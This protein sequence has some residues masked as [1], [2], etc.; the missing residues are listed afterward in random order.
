[1]SGCL[2]VG[3]PKR[4]NDWFQFGRNIGGERIYDTGIQFSFGQD[5]YCQQLGVHSL[6]HYY[7]PGGRQTQVT[8]T[9]P[10]SVGLVL[11]SSYQR[12]W[13]LDNLDAAWKTPDGTYQYHSGIPYGYRNKTEI[14]YNHWNFEIQYTTVSNDRD[15]ATTDAYRIVHFAIEPLSIHHDINM[16]EPQLT[17][18]MMDEWNAMASGKGKLH[19]EEWK[20]LQQEY[21]DKEARLH[22]RRKAL[23]EIPIRNPIPSCTAGSTAHTT[24][25]MVKENEGFQAYTLHTYDVTWIK[26]DEN[27]K[28]KAW[29][30]R[31]DVYLSMNNVIPQ[32]IHNANLCAGVSIALVLLMCTI[33]TIMRHLQS[34]QSTVFEEEQGNDRQRTLAIANIAL[35]PP[36]FCPLMIPVLCGYGA[37][38]LVTTV[39]VIGSSFLGWIS[40]V[41]RGSRISLA[42]V[43]WS[44]CGIVAGYTAGWLSR[45]THRNMNP[46]SLFVGL[47]LWGPGFVGLFVL[48]FQLWA[49]DWSSPY[50]LRQK[51]YVVLIILLVAVYIPLVRVGVW[52]AGSDK[53]GRQQRQERHSRDIPEDVLVPRQPWHCDG[54]LH[55]LGASI[56]PF[57]VIY[58]EV[59][60]IMGALWRDQ[61]YFSHTGTF[62]VV[63]ASA[64][65]IVAAQSVLLCH[66]QLLHRN[67]S[68]W[69]RAFW[70]GGSFGLHVLLYSFR[71]FQELHPVLYFYD[72]D[73]YDDYT[74]AL[75]SFYGYM[76]AFS[77]LLVC[78]GGFVGVVC[79]L[80][81][82]RHFRSKLYTIPA[83]VMHG[84]G[85]GHET[86]GILV[87][88]TDCIEFSKRDVA[89]R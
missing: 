87:V 6:R 73:D 70:N 68:W 37:Q 36:T 35:R 53:E 15:G 24:Q 30:S 69:W 2:G 54:M 17:S 47:I 86:E 34:K 50:E 72:Y 29:S 63:L 11:D 71:Y 66:W 46:R 20:R 32:G 64:L 31:W 1:M 18:G 89:L 28:E 77:L 41:R 38:A 4:S 27:E 78:M 52:A 65:A 51:S 12:H 33:V 67:H 62:F 22:Q 19:K 43:Y 7:H 3:T 23:E 13:I 84:N 76:T 16:T 74:G 44:I 5:K 57:S 85:K 40:P 82:L 59:Y 60:F 21:S 83:S 39:L 25:A 10:C 80:L 42:I 58:V 14:V 45:A 8:P 56:L 81:F 26:V 75:L 49:V 55:M 9:S 88:E 79:V 48:S 61:H